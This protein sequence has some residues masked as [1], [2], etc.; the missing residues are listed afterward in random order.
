MG[1]VAKQAYF[2]TINIAIGVVAGAVNTIIVLPHAFEE[3]PGDWGLVR[4]ILAYS[5]IIA[6]VF[7]FGTFN[8]IV[9]EFDSNQKEKQNNAILGFSMMLS[10]IGVLF[11]FLALFFSKSILLNLFEENVITIIYANLPLLF[12]ISTVFIFTQTFTGFL[13]AKHKT[14]VVQFTNDLFLKSSYLLLALV[15]WLNPFSF[16]L[17]LKLFVGIYLCSLVIYFIYSISIGFRINLQ[18]HLLK[19]K[20]LLTYGAFTILNRGAGIIVGNLDLIMIGLLLDLENVAYYVLA[21]YI[22]TVISIPQRAIMAPAQPLVSKFIREDD[23]SS[24]EK[25]YRQTSLNQ[26]IVGGVLFAL[27]WINIDSIYLLIPAKFSGGMWVVFFIGLSKLFMMSTGISGAIIIFSKY[28]KVNLIL[29]VLLIFLTIETN[30]I[31]ITKYGINGAA[32]ATSITYLAYNLLKVSYIKWR[33]NILPF[34]NEFIKSTF[35]IIIVSY[36]GNRL[37]LY[38]SQPILSILIKSL[39]AILIMLIAFNS[40]NVKAEIVELQKRILKKWLRQ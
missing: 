35:I 30:Y 34:N 25:I 2:N 32:L 8:I 4:S 38:P 9:R 24:L 20:E 13:N 21:F 10:S 12:A 18:F 33:F 11:L 19:I 15:Y 23:I 16:D 26:F 3:Y 6:Q 37:E 1:I 31:F 28:Y 39:I 29:N 7:G 14:P 5:I 40:M 27:I 22:G 17:Y 36:F